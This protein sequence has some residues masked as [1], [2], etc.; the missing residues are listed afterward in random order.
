MLGQPHLPGSGAQSLPVCVCQELRAPTHGLE[1][2]PWP[3]ST[4][5]GGVLGT[6]ESSATPRRPS[7]LGLPPH[8][9]M[10]PSARTEHVETQKPG[11]HGLRH[12]GCHRPA[13]LQLPLSLLPP[14]LISRQMF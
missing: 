8:H 6:L 7:L 12:Q 13:P 9:S 5:W 14:L 4:R 10:V 2:L 1:P 11:C 3:P